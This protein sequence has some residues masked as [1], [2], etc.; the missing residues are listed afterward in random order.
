MANR[1]KN[2][3]IFASGGGSNAE[4]MIRQFEG[5]VKVRVSLIVTNKPQAGVVKIAENNKIPVLYVNKAQMQEPDYLIG[6]LRSAEIDLIVLAGFLWLI[7]AWL[8]EAWPDQIINIH[9]ALLPAFGG[10]GM[11]GHYIHEAV[12]AS[13]VTETGLTIHLVNAEYDKGAQLFQIKCPVH[14]DDTPETIAARVLKL[15]HKWYGKVVM[16]YELT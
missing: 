1:P 8:V 11:Y 14:L 6:A 13:G 12:K 2:I 15:E 5:S 9:P 4:A 10:Q 16:N 3:A 7:P